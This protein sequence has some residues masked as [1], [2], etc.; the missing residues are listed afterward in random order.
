[1][2]KIRTA[3]T[4]ILKDIDAEKGS[5]SD[6]NLAWWVGQDDFEWLTTSDI[7]ELEAAWDTRF[8]T[9]GLTRQ[10]RLD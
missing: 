5:S 2:N 6:F 7:G 9:T 1:M 10:V 8:R 3:F 4:Q